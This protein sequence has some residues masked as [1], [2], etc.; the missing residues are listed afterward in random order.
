MVLL[1]GWPRPS[2]GWAATYCAR[3]LILQ[4]VCPARVG[5]TSD[6]FWQASTR[7]RAWMSA[8][9]RRGGGHLG[10]SLRPSRRLLGEAMP[11]D[12]DGAYGQTHVVRDGG[13]GL[14]AGDTQDDL[15]T[16]GVLLGRGAGGHAALQ[17]GAFG[18]QQTNTS[19]DGVWNETCETVLSVFPTTTGAPPHEFPSHI[20]QQE[21]VL[22]AWANG[23]S[24]RPKNDRRLSPQS[25][26]SPC[27]SC[28][29]NKVARPA[30]PGMPHDRRCQGRFWGFQ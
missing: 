27:S 18:G 6:G 17:F 26:P 8:W 13:V 15:G 7:S 9:Y 12:K 19:Y 23:S 20:N 24:V 3:S 25:H 4:W 29:A 30:P 14:T 11:P 5:S 21:G 1:L 2:S 28:T 16:I 22:V 10:R